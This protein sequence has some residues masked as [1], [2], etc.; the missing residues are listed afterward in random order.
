LTTP[1]LLSIQ[2]GQPADHGADTI[3]DKPWRSGIF[4]IPVAGRVWVDSLNV[5]GDGQDDRKNHGGPFRAVL[6]YSA[7]HYPLWNTELGRDLDCGSFGENFTVAGLSESNVCL[8]DVYAVGEIRLQVSQ[9]RY[10]CWKL[11]RR[12]GVKDLAERVERNGWGGWYNRVLQTGCVQAGD[13]VSLRE[14][15]YPQYSIAYLNDLLMKRVTNPVACAELATLETLSPEWR[16]N[17][18]RLVR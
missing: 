13:A 17:Y 10:P 4:K 7:D 3:S 6:A 5:A 18:A 14:R 9:P 1:T 8:G 12:V 2:I 15:L 11:A 16:E